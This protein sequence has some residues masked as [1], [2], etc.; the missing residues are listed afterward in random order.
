MESGKE[1]RRYETLFILNPD[2]GGKLKDYIE[3]FKQVLT[4]LGAEVSG[5]E[6]WG[7]RDLAYRIQNQGRGIYSLI[8]YQGA[9]GAVNELERQMKMSD[10]VIR[11]MTVWVENDEATSS[12]A[13]DKGPAEPS[14]GGEKVGRQD[15][16]S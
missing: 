15:A 10:G 6:E 11:H 12:P 13:G 2:E 8:R 9:T 1:L 7:V 5:V 16:E 3:R 4:G 14:Q